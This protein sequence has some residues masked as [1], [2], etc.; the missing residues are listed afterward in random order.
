MKLPVEEP[1]DIEQPVTVELP[2]SR[3]FVFADGD[4]T[5]AEPG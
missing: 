3:T 4:D 1:L 2:P 5:A